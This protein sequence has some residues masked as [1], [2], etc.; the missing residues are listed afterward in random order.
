MDI[1]CANTYIM[2]SACINMLRKMQFLGMKLTLCI[3]VVTR[4]GKLCGRYEQPFVNR[5]TFEYI[6]KLLY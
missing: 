6:T 1:S 4:L 3:L 2:T 5:V